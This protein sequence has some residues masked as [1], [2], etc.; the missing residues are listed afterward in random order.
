MI[1]YLPGYFY[2]GPLVKDGLDHVRSQAVVL[3]HD[4][5]PAKLASIPG[6][7]GLV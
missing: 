7:I 4:T 3:D 6:G 5:S 1:V 2:P